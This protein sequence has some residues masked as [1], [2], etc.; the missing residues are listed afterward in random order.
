ML[1]AVEQV[2]EHIQTADPGYA[3]WTTSSMVKY[4]NN[5]VL[6]RTYLPP[7]WHRVCTTSSSIPIPPKG[8]MGVG[9]VDGF[10]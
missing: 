5:G 7:L 10:M 3:V 4:A 6:N 2:P 1:K 9:Y 8:R